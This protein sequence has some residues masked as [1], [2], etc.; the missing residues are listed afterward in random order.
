MIKIT[1]ILLFI[2]FF[3]GSAFWSADAQIL[4]KD[5]YPGPS[6]STIGFSGKIG[7]KLFF[8]AT[9]P[10]SELW[11]SDRAT[12]SI[13]MVGPVLPGVDGV[14]T[15][16]SKFLL[17]RDSLLV[18]TTSSNNDVNLYFTDGSISGTQHIK[19]LT[20]SFPVL[21]NLLSFNNKMYFQAWDNIHGTEI[22]ESDATESGT[23]HLLNP[24]NGKPVK[25]PV[26][27][28]QYNNR[29]WFSSLG[30]F[31]YIDSLSLH[32]S[33][34]YYPNTS[35]SLELFVN[36]DAEPAYFIQ[37]F[38]NALNKR[39]V[40][41][42]PDA[43][44]EIL[45]TTLL[46]KTLLLS[47]KNKKLLYNEVSTDVYPYTRKI[48]SL[49]AIT[50]DT[51]LLIS[52]TSTNL[53]NGFTGWIPGNKNVFLS[54]YNGSQLMDF[55]VT[56]GT[57]AG[58]SRIDI[59]AGVTSGTVY[60]LSDTENGG[61][62]GASGN[63]FLNVRKGEDIHLWITDGSSAGTQRIEVEGQPLSNIS[64]STFLHYGNGF[65]FDAYHPLY[66]TELWYSNGTNS[67]TK[68]LADMTP[69]TKSTSFLP[70]SVNQD[71]LFMAANLSSDYGRE[72]YAYPIDLCE[73][74]VCPE[75]FECIYGECLPIDYCVEVLCPEGQVCYQGGCFEGCLDGSCVEIGPNLAAGHNAT[76]EI[77]AGSGYDVYEWST[78]ENEQKIK[79][80]TS[81]R[82]W[83]TAY[84]LAGGYFGSDTLSV[85]FECDPNGLCPEGFEC[86]DGYCINTDP[87]ADVSCPE[88]EVCFQG[89]CFPGCVD[90]ST[91][92]LCLFGQEFVTAP[93]ENVTCPIGYVCYEG[94]CFPD[95]CTD[96]ECPLGT[97][98]YEG[99]CLQACGVDGDC[100]E[101]KTCYNGVCI[102]ACTGVECP[103]GTACYEGECL[104]TCGNIE[105][106]PEGMVCY[107]GVCM[108][109]CDNVQCPEGQVCHQ[110]GCFEG[111]VGED[112]IDFGPNL[113]ATHST[114]IILDAGSGFDIYEW[115]TGDTTQ[116]VLVDQ[117]GRYW[118]IAYN[119]STNTYSSDT[120][121]VIFECNPQGECPEGFDCIDGYCINTDLCADA[122]CPAGSECFEGGCFPTCLELD[123]SGN[124]HFGQE[125]VP[126]PCENVLCSEGDVCYEGGCFPTNL[127]IKTLNSSYL[128]IYP[129]PTRNMLFTNSKQDFGQV[130][131]S[132]Y[133]AMGGLI[134]SRQIDI[135]AG[136]KTLLH[137]FSA[138]QSGLYFIELSKNGEIL[139]S[140][141][142][143]VV[144]Q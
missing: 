85:I 15:F 82:Y 112:C 55:W 97:T 100:P 27:F 61:F 19:T 49:D 118:V 14:V 102:D 75:G 53:S 69:G 104:P 122:L 51:S 83:V 99:E 129:N 46:D 136:E 73:G 141:N 74:V 5:F 140:G 143:V 30:Q 115:S 124:C 134:Q 26:N 6:S 111:C 126:A 128:S 2:F 47:Y 90:N 66:G 89:G 11:L 21:K 77:D 18:F 81:G 144:K 67:G 4:I 41:V 87:C 84:N 113:S 34:Y 132:I 121:S 137:E 86:I 79:V 17:F 95:A 64:S 43:S 123:N 91:S 120:I 92:D 9:D 109:P 32:L 93:C 68:L 3:S 48:I 105:D 8:T 63:I 65:V 29:L 22:W 38:N 52:F 16:N 40:K 58:T 20:N 101:G 45:D 130:N 98:C 33:D 42:N 13:N 39:L 1:P 108:D 56:D 88:G 60:F 119:L 96:V 71:T 103:L 78:G 94:G 117:S 44:I 116:T 110:G 131:L 59:L 138:N 10:S 72:L 76:I 135:F 133:N 35:Y 12:G 62:I 125:F 28:T 70:L 54:L 114:T 80:K 31:W 36:T 37:P 127:S 106:C 57:P 139:H 25:S 7:D 50:G 107:D 23:H 142:I 24:L